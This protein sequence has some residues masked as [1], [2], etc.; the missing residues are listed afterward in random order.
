MIGDS[1]A[2]ASSATEVPFR[3]N[4]EGRLTASTPLEPPLLSNLTEAS[5]TATQL[6]R[7]TLAMPHIVDTT[8]RIAT[9]TYEFRTANGDTLVATFTGQATLVS[10]GVLSVLDT[11]LI[12]GGTGRF[13]G[14]TGSF[15]ADRVF[16]IATGEITGSFEGKI[17]SPGASKR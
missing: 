13:A 9:G 10:P 12:S 4:L 8:T 14:A 6:G 2:R 7:F 1:V 3:G 17:S 11:A 5:G 16:V 15:T